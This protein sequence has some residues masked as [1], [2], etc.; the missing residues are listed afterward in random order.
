MIKIKFMII[1]ILEFKLKIKYYIILQKMKIIN[2]YKND[3]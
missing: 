2:F 3:K 1:F